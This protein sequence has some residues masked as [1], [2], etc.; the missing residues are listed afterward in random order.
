[1]ESVSFEKDFATSNL[2]GV[3]DVSESLPIFFFLNMFERIK[4]VN[5]QTSVQILHQQIMGGGGS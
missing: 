5:K 2:G 4:V 3:E 1:M